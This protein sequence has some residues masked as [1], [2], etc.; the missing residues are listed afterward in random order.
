MQI[1]TPS[2]QL[3]KSREEYDK[4][5]RHA[6]SAMR[7]EAFK[8]KRAT[9]LAVEKESRKGLSDAQER[10][11]LAAQMRESHRLRDKEQRHEVERSRME[12]LRERQA[13]R[14]HKEKMDVGRVG[15]SEMGLMGTSNGAGT[16]NQLLQM[17][18]LVEYLTAMEAR[19]I[20]RPEDLGQVNDA[21]VAALVPM[22]KM[23]HQRKLMNLCKHY[24]PSNLA[25]SGLSQRNARSIGTGI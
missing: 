24:R 25:H 7:L 15:G 10:S 21:D 8:E 18:G 23:I 9:R 16:L 5:E 13:D 3:R 20:R 6:A 12:A 17:A 19:G 11:S 2:P 22:T 4:K 1:S 14:R